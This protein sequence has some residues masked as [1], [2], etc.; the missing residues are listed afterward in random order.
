L[1]IEVKKCEESGYDHKGG[2]R[3]MYKISERESSGLS[4]G[5]YDELG[6]L[7]HAHER[8][9]KVLYSHYWGRFWRQD[10]FGYGG[11]SLSAH[12]NEDLGK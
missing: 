8:A 5:L 1:A 4:Q 11:E 7:G 9:M 2:I 10:A 6:L 12:A 3:T